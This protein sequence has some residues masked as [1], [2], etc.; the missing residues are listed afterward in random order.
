VQIKIAGNIGG[1]C[2]AQKV[3]VKGKVY[4]ITGYEVPE[5]E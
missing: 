4:P 1:E 2:V 5:G 3:T